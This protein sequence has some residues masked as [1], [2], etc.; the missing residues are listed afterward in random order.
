MFEGLKI[1]EFSS[2]LAGPLVGSFFAEL[3]AN[4]IKVE[5]KRSQGDPTRK[6]KLKNEDPATPVSAYYASANYAKQVIMLDLADPDDKFEAIQLVEDCD[7][8]I[9]NLRKSSAGKLGISYEQLHAV[10]AKLIYACISGYA[11]DDDRPAFDLVL[12]AETGYMSMTGEAGGNPCKVPIAFIDVMAAHHLKQGVL[13]ALIR[14]M[15]TGK[16]SFV[17]ISLYEAALAS[18]IN[19]GS[20][21][22]MCG[23]VPSAMGSLH[24]NIAPYG[25]CLQTSDGKTI[26]LAVGTEKQF[27]SLAGLIKLEDEAFASNALRLKNRELLFEKLSSAFRQMHLAYWTENLSKRDIPFAQIKKIDEVLDAKEAQAKILSSNIEGVDTL[28]MKTAYI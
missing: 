7:I 13:C 12:Q 18:L 11:Y 9:S 21:Y 24:P 4:V 22:L 10:N 8:V 17:H 2:V 23:F 25:E 27:E 19:Q 6:W 20:N 26:V 1:V 14:R 16:G 15:K 28:R 5:N 3:G